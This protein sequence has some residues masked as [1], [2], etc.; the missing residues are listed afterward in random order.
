[1]EKNRLDEI[2]RLSG[3]ASEAATEVKW[4]RSKWEDVKVGD[5]I[6]LFCG[7]P[8]SVLRIIPAP[9]GTKETDGIWWF[10]KRMKTWVVSLEGPGFPDVTVTGV[11][12]PERDVITD[13]PVWVRR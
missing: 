3:A 11:R 10:N 12:N 6:S 2:E 4:T 13:Q 1:V 5:E 8:A 7:V 9:Q